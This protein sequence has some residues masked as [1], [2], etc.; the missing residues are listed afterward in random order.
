MNIGIDARPAMKSKTGVGNYVLR[1]ATHLSRLAPDNQYHLYHSSYKDRFYQP[2]LNGL[3]HCVVHDYKIPNRVMDF[4]WNRVG[5]LPLKLLF[6]GMN[7]FH[8]TGNI[9][10]PLNSIPTVA[11]MYDLFHIKYPQ[12]VEPRYRIPVDEL[13]KKLAGVDKIIAISAFTKTDLMDLLDIAP[14]KISVIPLGVDRDVFKPI[15]KNQAADFLKKRLHLEGD[16]I[17][18]VGNLETRKNLPNLL[19]A[20]KRVREIHPSLK[21]VL[22]GAQGWGFERVFEKLVVEQ[23]NPWVR[24]PGYLKDSDLVNLYS[25]A[26]AFVLPSVYEG[27]GLPLL[28]AFACG[29][30]VACA[31]TTSIPETAGNAALLFDP[32]RPEE[33]AEQI[34]LILEDSDLGD[35]LRARGL[36]QAE[37]FQWRKTASNTL[38]IYRSLGKNP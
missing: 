20:V 16:Y 1:L 33:I 10:L 24:L 32:L 23:M 31:N 37:Q 13:K 15:A 27:F 12:A 11:T 25:G 22:A 21:L 17:L 29:T 35:H 5:G 26:S 4:L 8:Y 19:E 3:S 28:E 38:E 14:N 7:L 34:L 18:F 30:P 36:A 2:D 9:S 6:K